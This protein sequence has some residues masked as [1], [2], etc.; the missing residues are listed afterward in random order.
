MTVS[1]ALREHSKD[2]L[3]EI[4]IFKNEKLQR[5][6]SEAEDQEREIERLRDA[7]RPFAEAERSWM[8]G[9]VR[10]EIRMDWLTAAREAVDAALHPTPET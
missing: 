5:L 9:G 4:I 7:L 6:I 2:K 1:E 3:I 10:M 8:A